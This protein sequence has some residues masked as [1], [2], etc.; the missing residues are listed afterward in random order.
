MGRIFL[1]GS[2]FEVLFEFSKYG[3][4]F[5][6]GRLFIGGGN[7]S[8]WGLRRLI[9]YRRGRCN[10]RIVRLCRQFVRHGRKYIINIFLIGGRVEMILPGGFGRIFLL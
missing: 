4:D 10:T 1:V 6:T 9:I 3:V 7:I 5:L 2:A 8:G